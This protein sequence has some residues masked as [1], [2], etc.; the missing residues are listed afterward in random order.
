MSIILELA[1]HPSQVRSH[2]YKR[3]ENGCGREDTEYEYTLSEKPPL[4]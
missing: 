3:E 2:K 4:S 1:S